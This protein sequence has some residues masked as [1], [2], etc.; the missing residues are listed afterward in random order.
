MANMSPIVIIEDDI[1]DRDT[2]KEVIVE[3]NIPNPT[4]FFT[5]CSD[6]FSF[7]KSTT[8]QPFII[9]CDINLPKQSGLNFKQ[10][11]DN[12]LQLRQKSIPFIFLSTAATKEIV[13]EA[14]TKMTVQGF[15]KKPASVHDLKKAVS[16]IYEYWKLSNHP[17]IY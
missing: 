12:D 2:L 4:I 14:F 6:A 1:D 16:A 17:N 9:L 8:D 13:T 5:R 7:L 15:F 10:Q 3:L 11:I